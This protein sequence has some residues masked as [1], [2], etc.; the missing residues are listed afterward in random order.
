MQ[1]VKFVSGILGEVFRYLAVKAV[2]MT[3]EKREC[4]LTLDGVSFIAGDKFDIWSGSFIGDVPGLSGAATH[5]LVI[6]L[7]C[8]ATY[9]KQAVA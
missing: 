6:M 3:A 5:G 9:W 8:I 4:C 2:S 7:S 1:H